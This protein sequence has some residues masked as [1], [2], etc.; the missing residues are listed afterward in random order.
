MEIKINI[1]QCDNCPHANVYK[2]YTTDSWDNVRA[3]ECRLLKEDV[4]K[5]LD[6]Y[7]KSPVPENCPAKV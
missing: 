7:D 4:H 6:W 5:Y 1:D 2:V 3:I